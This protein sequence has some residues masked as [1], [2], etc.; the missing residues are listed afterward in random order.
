MPHATVVACGAR[1]GRCRPYKTCGADGASSHWKSAGRRPS[2]GVPRSSLRSHIRARSGASGAWPTASSA[3]P[4]AC[5]C[6]P[7]AACG[8]RPHATCN[9]SP[10]P[11]CRPLCNDRWRGEGGE[12]DATIGG[13]KQGRRP[14]RRYTLRLSSP[15]VR[16]LVECGRQPSTAI[17]CRA[18]SVKGHA[19]HRSA[20][21]ARAGAAACAAAALHAGACAAVPSRGGWHTPRAPRGRPRARRQTRGGRSLA[22]PSRTP[23]TRRQASADGRRH[24]PAGDG[25]ARTAVSSGRCRRPAFSDTRR[26]GGGLPSAA[27]RCLAREACGAACRRR[28]AGCA[29]ARAADGACEGEGTA[30]GDPGDRRS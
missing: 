15:S 17:D 18:C 21:S 4:A 25:D 22:A 30:A 23:T 9:P 11:C 20:L 29:G 19:A 27:R 3:W 26:A 28:H 13:T 2:R 16:R 12:R 6:R 14:S 1:A 8:C 24:R 10:G 5:R 7:H